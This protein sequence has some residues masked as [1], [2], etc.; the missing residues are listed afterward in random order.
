MTITED[1][2]ITK[3]YG[4]PVGTLVGIPR[5]PYSSTYLGKK[6]LNHSTP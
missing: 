2:T 6:V 4:Y 3:G 1:S 5:F